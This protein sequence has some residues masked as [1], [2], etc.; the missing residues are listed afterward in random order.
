MRWLD[1][2]VRVN[3]ANGRLLGRTDE[4]R[5]R[6]VS[7]VVL[8]GRGM[9]IVGLDAQPA[10]VVRRTLVIMLRVL[11]TEARVVGARRD[12]GRAECYKRPSR[13]VDRLC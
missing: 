8:D 7:V 11:R 3:R 12:D 4:T 2:V 10:K 9:Q 5:V 6:R 13:L 1:V